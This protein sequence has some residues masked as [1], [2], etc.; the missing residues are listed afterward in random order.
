MEKGGKDPA[1]AAAAKKEKV[2]RTPDGRKDDWV[3][4]QLRRVYDDALSEPIPDDL[5]SLLQ[6]IDKNAPPKA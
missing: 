3:G 4:R 2:G 5:M 6:Q 1:G